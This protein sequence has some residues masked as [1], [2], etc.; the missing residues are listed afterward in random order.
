MIT[1]MIVYC[2]AEMLLLFV[3]TLLW[4]FIHSSEKQRKVVITNLSQVFTSCFKQ[5]PP[6]PIVDPMMLVRLGA[7]VAFAV[8]LNG[9][10]DLV[11]SWWDEVLVFL[12]G[13]IAD[14]GQ[15]VVFIADL[16]VPLYNLFVTFNSQLTTG[17]YTIYAKCQLKTVIEALVHIGEAMEFYAKA[18]SG[19]IL[20]PKGAF[21]IYNTTGAIQSAVMKQEVVLKCACDG[22]TPA[23]GIAFD[24]V[25]P[26][27]V[28]NITNETINAFL[29]VPQTA[30]L[31]I[32]PWKE[33]PDGRRVFQ[34]LKRLAV[35]LGK[36][37][38]EVLDSV[39]Q[40]ILLKPSR[41][42]P[43]FS[44]VGYFVEGILGLTE[45]G[46]HVM[47]RII[48]QHP[49]TFDPQFVHKSFV[50][51]VDAME[52]AF[53]QILS[54]I[55][56]P[57]NL[58]SDVSN[59][60]TE[61][62]ADAYNSIMG[63]V[64]N[65]ASIVGGIDSAAKPLARTLG[66]LT[67]SLVGIGMSV[68]DQ[69]LFILRGEHAG[70]SFM[71][72]LQRWD[73]EWGKQDQSGIRI[74]EHFFQNIDKATVA[75]EDLFSAFD[76]IPIVIRIVSRLVN[77]LL[78]TVLSA[79]DIVQDKYFHKP[80]NCG[81]GTSE[82]CS[83][84]CMYF[85]DPQNPYDVTK[86]DQNV[87]NS[88]IFEWIFEGFEDLIESLSGLFQKVR[89]QGEDWCRERDYPADTSDAIGD[90]IP[91]KRCVRSNT[92][93][94]C[95]TSVTTKEGLRVLLYGLR[96]SIQSLLTVFAKAGD[97][98]NL[99]IEYGLCEISTVLYA[100][101][102]NIISLFPSSVI[103]SEMKEDF[104][105]FLHAAASAFV[106]TYR[107][108]F[109]A[110]NYFLSLIT[111][112][113]V[114]WTG[115]QETIES[116]LISA[117][118][119]KV[120]QATVTTETSIT[121][122][123]NTANFLVT[124][125]IIPANVIINVLH[126]AGMLLGGDNFFTGLAEAVSV[127]K[128]ALSKEMINLISLVFKIGTNIL[129][130]ITQG[131]TDVGELA[132]DI[133]TLLKKG[134]DILA[135][136][137]SQILLNILELLGPIGDFIITLWR[138]LCAVAGS[139]EW[140]TGADF[141]G[142]CDAVE[143]VDDARRRLP[144]MQQLPI[145]MTGFDGN[146]ECDLLVHHYNGRLWEEATYLE[147]VRLAHCAEQQAIVHKMN[148][149]LQT[150]LPTD[151]IYNWKRKYNMGYEAALGFIVYMKHQDTAHMLAEWDRL[152]L[153][154]YYL[155]LWHRVKVE[156][157]WITILDD[158]FTKTIEPM[159][160][161]TSMYDTAKESLVKL[162]HVTKKHNMLSLQLPDIKIKEFKLGA[163]YHKIVSHH[164]MA[165]G[166]YTDID[167]PAGALKC[168]V[169]DNFVRAMT[170]ATMRVEQY[171]SG[172]FTNK[173]LPN[174]IMWMQNIST[175][176]QYPDYK[177]P[178][179]YIPTKQEAQ[180]AVLYSFQKCHYEDIKCDAA[181]ELARIGRITESLFYVGYVLVSM[182]LFSIVTGVSPF[183]LM[184]LTPL[185]VLAHTWNFRLTCIP[186]IPDCIFDDTLLWIQTYK[187]KPWD[188][189]FP[190]MTAN[191]S[192]ECPDNYLWSS[193]Y[194]L[195]RSPLNKLVEFILYQNEEAHAT[196]ID[197]GTETD[198]KNECIYIKAPSLIFTPLML[199]GLYAFSSTIMWGINAVTSYITLALPII[200]TIYAIES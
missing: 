82:D 154:R 4:F 42:I 112:E 110:A 149:V 122:Q 37:Y 72:I 114:D 40:R 9:N 195:A 164:T 96:Y 190:T 57:L 7:F 68:I 158:A 160:E 90:I 50:N 116:Q 24:F 22:L 136:L 58:G 103:S 137:A 31:A 12:W 198:F 25:R 197:W 47:V 3:G 49:I 148:A 180:D 191:P 183:P 91:G 28:A 74:Q 66:F 162:H 199:Y 166:L 104:A 176:K 108:V 10:E 155:D 142:I 177:I 11:K 147:Q 81:Y 62:Y 63:T 187:P 71:E 143:T 2:L 5:T 59:S 78:R 179:P 46:V 75:A 85:W 185:I 146:S 130:M 61:D 76:F 44:A 16:L 34:P 157:P 173:A 83:D 43:L 174:F 45:A 159:P 56:E 41:N 118:Y 27:L 20:A 13:I 194:L 32:P 19:F 131:K 189:Y 151:M 101:V 175:A 193:A 77:V 15:V 51:A 128:N 125:V 107:F 23:F 80:L 54:A 97:V 153:P 73:G 95:A 69:A 38:D 8:A 93:F 55:V 21:D 129:A 141:S 126:S 168:T 70:L 123:E 150:E 64:N 109:V 178:V 192:M 1:E 186:N 163:A 30:V 181:D 161:L 196:Y 120:E 67:K 29:A 167:L 156:I 113:T 105:D 144:A 200:S 53:V 145:N 6:P 133:I 48:L 99:D 88:L 26:T 86:D 111:G 102:G 52:I 127:F 98:K 140:L 172:P 169:A 170:D 124:A 152:E 121:L 17:T 182:V 92:D 119:R 117:E 18:L 89:P 171:Y 94:F 135:T 60:I 106:E 138:G 100:A 184:S 33:I 39:L 65:A 115:M 134:F 36:Y 87:C 139:I 14:F 84:E 35:A 79:E 188:D 132:E 165:W